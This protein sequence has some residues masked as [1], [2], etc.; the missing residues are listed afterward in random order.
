MHNV[1]NNVISTVISIMS[2]RIYTFAFFTNQEGLVNFVYVI[3][4]FLRLIAC[5]THS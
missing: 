4:F 2:N 1:N 5:N 3:I